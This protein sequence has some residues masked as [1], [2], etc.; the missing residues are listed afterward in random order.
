MTASILI[1]SFSHGWTPRDIQQM[2]LIY[3]T[4][5]SFMLAS[6]WIARV[7]GR[8]TS[9]YSLVPE[10]WTL[11]LNMPGIAVRIPLLHINPTKLTLY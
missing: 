10:V 9:T 5:L 1:S 8:I 6:N 7:M 11:Y 2:S 4:V 3:C